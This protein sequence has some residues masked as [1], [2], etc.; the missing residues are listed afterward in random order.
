MGI[1]QREAKKEEHNVLDL[2]EHVV[3]AEKGHRGYCAGRNL[4]SHY[5]HLAAGDCGDKEVVMD[6]QLLAAGFF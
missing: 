3:Q 5:V 2:P 4:G 6:I 1:S